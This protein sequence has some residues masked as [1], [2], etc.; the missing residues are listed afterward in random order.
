M[1]WWLGD[2]FYKVDEERT[3]SGIE[4]NTYFKELNRA[5]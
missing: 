4:R 1:E 2:T 3:L 5:F